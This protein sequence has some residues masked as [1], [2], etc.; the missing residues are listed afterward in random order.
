MKTFWENWYPK[1]GQ[2]L[3]SWAQAGKSPGRSRPGKDQAG[4]GPGKDQA[5]TGPGQIND[6]H[7]KRDVGPK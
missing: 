7:T 6:D 2:A 4:V 5:G 3:G 1:I